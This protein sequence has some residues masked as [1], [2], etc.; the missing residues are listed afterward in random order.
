MINNFV[1]ETETVFRSAVG[2]WFPSSLFIDFCM[3]RAFFDTGG[4]SCRSEVQILKIFSLTFVYVR[5]DW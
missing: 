2:K 4:D 5:P 1:I 3:A